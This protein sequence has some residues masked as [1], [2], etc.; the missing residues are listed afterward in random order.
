MYKV[1]F[2]RPFMTG[3]ELYYIAEAK[4]G[5]MLAGDGPFTKRCHDWLKKNSHCEKA[6][7]THSCTAAL[8]MAALLL[9]IEPGDEIIMPSYTFVS[10]ANA[11]VLRGGVPIFIDIREDTLNLD[12]RLIESAITPRTRAIVPVHY[13]GVA[14]EMDTIMAIAKR[15]GLRVVEDAAQG[16]MATYKGRALGSIGD[17]G[18][19]S[20]HETKNVISGEGGALLVN[21]PSLAMRAEIIR[22]KGTD[23]SCFFRGE[24]D[25]Y[26]WQEVGSSFL[27]GE[28][29]AAF[30]WAQLEEAE[31]ITE[32]R[33]EIWQRYNTLLEP[34]EAQ[35]LLRRPIVPE[36]CK[37]N[38]HMYY[39]LLAPEIDRQKV[40]NELKK[41]NIFSVFH[42]VP[43]HSSPAGQRYGR[44]HGD[45]KVTVRQSE[46]LVRL[47]LWLGLSAAEQDQIIEILSKALG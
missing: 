42:Y 43:L 18:A 12:E 34:L 13:A 31:R 8:E 17:L 16:V 20:F 7:L 1:P 47:P 11:F 22:E 21:D 37:H 35:G 39:V 3:K 44:T 4:F 29:I 25:K 23:R 41:N 46:R 30:L 33:L 28:L 40:L 5:N 26:T 10:T 2:N 45:L 14:C 32:S 15:Y 27:P 38:A 36:E 24:V 6:L 19:Y 9:D